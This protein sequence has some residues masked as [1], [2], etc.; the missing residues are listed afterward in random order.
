MFEA[1]E[2][3]SV[4]QPK[5]NALVDA[6]DFACLYSLLKSHVRARRTGCG[7]SVG[8]IDDSD[9]IPLPNHSCQSSATRDFDVI[10]MGS[11]SDDV[12]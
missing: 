3:L 12:Q 1:I 6:Q 2:E 11:N 5:L 4:G 9:P 8:Q 10:G 7:F